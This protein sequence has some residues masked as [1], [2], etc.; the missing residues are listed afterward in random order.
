MNSAVVF[1]VPNVIDYVRIGLLT[2]SVF[3]KGHLFVIFY[4]LSVSL[5]FFDGLAARKLGQV[6]RLGACLDMVVDR[7][8]TMVILGKIAVEKPRYAPWCLLYSKIDFMSHFIFFLVSAYTNA[9]HKK[10]SNNLLLSL[11]YNENFLYLMCLGS[12]LCFVTVY[13]LNSKAQ[14]NAL[15]RALAGMLTTIAVVKTFF[16]VV[17]FVVG[18]GMLSTLKEPVEVKGD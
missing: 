2:M 9:H 15:L 4:A 16:H 10:F 13:L 17:H 18:V 3:L 1:Y 12:E 11:Y 14:K 8:S 6:S 7:V 5:D